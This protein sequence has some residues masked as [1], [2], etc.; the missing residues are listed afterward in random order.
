[1]LACTHRPGPGTKITL[2]PSGI[3][4][5]SSAVE[6]PGVARTDGALPGMDLAAGPDGS[7]P[8]GERHVDLE[9]RHV[10]VACINSGINLSASESN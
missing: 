8:A 2:N 4:R 6:Q 5:P 7:E 1:M 3:E 10:R 9:V